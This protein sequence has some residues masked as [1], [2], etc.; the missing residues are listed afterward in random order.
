MTRMKAAFLFLLPLLLLN[1]CRLPFP[2]TA[3]PTPL[4]ET[5]WEL[6]EII[7]TPVAATGRAYLRFHADG[8]KVVE[9]SGGCNRFSGRYDVTDG[10]LSI[11]PLLAT[12]MACPDMRE[13]A[14]FFAALQ[15]ADAY[16]L[17][18]ETLLL[19]QKER[20][21]LRLKVRRPHP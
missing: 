7:G 21:L 18:N 14:A 13:E 12:K 3:S 11:G 2:G 6:S 17:E 1:G 5:S 4:L 20:P 9:G 10:T 8:D 19:L 15:R 16:R